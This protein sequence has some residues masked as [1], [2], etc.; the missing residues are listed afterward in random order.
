MLVIARLGED[1]GV[2]RS[3]EETLTGLE[4]YGSRGHASEDLGALTIDD[5]QL[6]LRRDAIDRDIV[7]TVPKDTGTTR[8]QEETPR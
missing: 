3:L 6:C 8:T 4:S 1:K 7:A 2:G 5:R